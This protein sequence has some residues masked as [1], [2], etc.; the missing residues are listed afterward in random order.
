MSWLVFILISV[1]FSA[2][3]R[4]IQRLLLGKG[5]IDPIAFSI[6]F[7]VLT[8]IILL[9]YAI[10]SGFRFPDI[11]K[12]WFPAITSIILFGIGNIA[13]AKSLQKVEA[14]V[15][16]VLFA[17]NV[18]W[19][20][21]FG[22]LIFGESISYWH[23]IGSALTFFSIYLLV[24]RKGKFKFDSGIVYGLL[25]ALCMGLAVLG[26]VYVGRRSDPISW[27]SITFLAPAAFNAMTNPRSL[28]KTKGILTK[29]TFP[30]LT[31]ACVTFAI[32]TLT[33]LYAYKYGELTQVAPI[34][35]T[36]IIIT[37]ILAIIFLK[38]REN[39]IRKLMSA[40]ICFC[41]VLLLVN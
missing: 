29:D 32:S 28:A 6:V 38:E 33:L 11:S 41:G 2:F 8:G 18:V 13:L 4:L 5:K 24:E 40:I 25:C 31:L 17:T 35:Q 20:M 36:T 26:W 39:L 9:L 1:T 15:F 34:S 3:T 27:N 10:I 14:S 21:L 19:I 30:K 7:Q 12:Y 22:V 23:I 37:V 16:T